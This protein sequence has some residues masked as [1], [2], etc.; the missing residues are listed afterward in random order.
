MF[1]LKTVDIYRSNNRI[2]GCK[3]EKNLRRNTTAIWPAQNGLSMQDCQHDA[4]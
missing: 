3:N 1:K 4:H 2:N